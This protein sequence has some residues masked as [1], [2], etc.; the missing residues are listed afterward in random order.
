[1][2]NPFVLSQGII[3]DGRSIVISLCALFFGPLAGGIAAGMAFIYRIMIGGSGILMGTGV[4]IT[5]F[6]IGY[7][8][9]IQKASAAHRKI[10]NVNL[11]QFGLLVHIAMLLLVLL[12][13]VKDILYVYKTITFT[14]ILIYPLVTLLVGRILLDQ[15][16]N[17]LFVKKLS[18]NEER[19][20]L[21]LKAGNQGL[22]DLNVQTG[23]AFVN[24]DYAAMLGYDPKTF[25]ESNSAW[26]ERLH[27]DDKDITAK[28]YLDYTEGKTQEYRVEFRQRTKDNKWK[29]ILSTGKIVDY[30]S[31]GKPLRMLGTHTDITEL[32]ETHLALQ[33]S[34]EKFAKIFRSSPDTITLSKLTNGLIVDVNEACL[35]K[36][37][38]AMNEIIGKTVID[39]NLWADINDRDKY[40]TQLLNRGKIANFETR[41]R[42]KSGELR[43]ALISGEVIELVGEKFI[44][45]T[46]RDITERKEIEKTL[47]ENQMRLQ[48]IVSNAPVILFG[49]DSDGVFT[50]SEGKGLHAL[51]LKPGE[52]VGKSAF[53]IYREFPSVVE[54]LKTALKGELQTGIH[55]MGDLTF[56]VYYTPIKSEN[57]YVSGL[58]GVATDIT[59]RKKAEEII[60][61]SEERYRT[62]VESMDISLCRWLPDTTLT[63]TNEKYR[64]IFGLSLEMANRKWL[65]FVPEETREATTRFYKEL[66][67]NPKVITY[68]HPVKLKD[69]RVRD[70][71]W[72]D[73]PIKDEQGSLTE[74]QS[75]GIDITERK[76]AEKELEE[77]HNNLVTTLESMRDGFV[78]LDPD[79]RYTY[80]NNI[81]GQIFGRNPAEMIGKHIWTE[82]PEGVGQP[83]HLAYE[84]AMKDQT[85]IFLEEYY[86]PYN[87]WFENR[88]YPNQK[89][90]SIFFTDITERK[91]SEQILRESEEKFRSIFDSTPVP[92]ALNDNEQNITLLNK[93]FIEA[94]GYTKEDIP[95]LDVWW[96]KAY[97]D[98]GYRQW[99]ASTWQNRINESRQTGEPFE[100]IELKIR[101][102]DGSLK[103]VLVGLSWLGDQGTSEQLV[104]LYDIT[105]RKL[106]EEEKQLLTNAIEASLNEIYIFDASTL[107]FKDINLG[108]TKNLGYSKN[109]L[110]TMTP[111][112]IKPQFTYETFNKL[113]LPL[114]ENK[115]ERLKFETIH[116]R[117][118][119]SHYPI[120][121]HLQ[122][123]ETGTNNFFLAII[124]DISE[125]KN[126]EQALKESE[127]RFHTMFEKHHA[128]MMLIEPESGKIV[129]ANLSA[130]K[131]YGY[132]IS[133]LCKMNIASINQ[134]SPSKLKEE[135]N[136][137][138]SESKMYFNFPHKLHSGEIKYVEVFTTPITVKDVTLLFS[139]IHDIT[140]RRIAEQE[141]LK[142]QQQLRALTAKLEQIREEERIHLSREL[143]DNL[144]QSLTGLKMDV[145]WLARNMSKK[146]PESVENILVKT[147]SMSELIDQTI[148]D[149]RRISSDLRPN[150]LDYLGLVA[151]LEWLISD[152][153]KRTEIDC[154]IIS[155]VKNIKLDAAVTN[156]VYRIIQEGLTNIARH[157]G[158]KKIEL[159]INQTDKHFVI[160]LSDDGGG[161]TK[162]QINNVNSLGIRGMKERVIQF[163]GELTFKGT[164]GRGTVITLNIPKGK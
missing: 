89:G 50:F 109:Q 9:F 35:E 44:L 161:I 144:G 1:M 112:D 6:L 116:R 117:A 93:A 28:A 126:A 13:P 129:D 3:F 37:G 108:A 149:V 4:I 101:C 104:I 45:G 134:L 8:F 2:H 143:H 123:F 75:V 147:K 84:K 138:S 139:I 100:P 62:L 51:G 57:G 63:F 10:S 71:H 53:E 56:E 41:F 80:M 21:S 64:Q 91:L 33:I 102:K 160:Q 155:K 69:G 46:I 70:Y 16:E 103:T 140:E 83:F 54:V 136:K 12:L 66:A 141:V 145:A 25:V 39:L 115:I 76:K 14:V 85:P 107:I 34:E 58:I 61:R 74:F 42:M 95:T 92:L 154:K 121:A 68:E 151:A 77:S 15:E 67:E 59:E 90:L 148:N 38:Y 133:E 11:Y 40:V 72:I 122:L 5:S 94:F 98:A 163:G 24:D 159:E 26:I 23:E 158:A 146:K 79:W 43:D 153:K 120:E 131:F 156:S 7:I 96:P 152:F 65:E 164:K 36:T 142:S 111:L 31:Y 135:L 97:P 19:L 106:I 130:E 55:E 73:M 60:R 132:P 81:A 125:R 113:L 27:P 119:G 105:E 88:I 82:F 17:I 49:L 18:D 47:F 124:N 87:K 86:S 114:R 78:S 137:A 128:V 127:E 150:L 32:K 30:D 99:I 110:L 52:V 20:R 48:S 157:A 162:E 118:D 22:Y 29:W